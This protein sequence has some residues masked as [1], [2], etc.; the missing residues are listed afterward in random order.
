MENREDVEK[1]LGEPIFDEFSENTLR[2]RRNLFFVSGVALFYKIGQL[3]ISEGQLGFFTIKNL[4]PEF[5]DQALFWVVAYLLIHFIWNSWSHFQE[6]HL[7]LTATRVAPITGG[8]WT[9]D[10][11]D[12]PTDP[13]Q[14]TLYNWWLSEAGR[15]GNIGK[16]AASIIETVKGWDKRIEDAIP[17]NQKINLENIIHG[18]T[19]MQSKISDMTRKIEQ[20]EKTLSSERIPAS[21][22]RF[23][24]S[25]WQFQKNQLARW[26]LVEWL[27]PI[28]L[29]VW[30]FSLTWP[31]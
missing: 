14:S 21:L 7:R 5:V 30:A 3:E 2:I 23:D 22:E 18:L 9:S 31:F 27:L 29:G 13:K 28:T 24:K 16:E 17:S 25:F 6:F 8:M 11:A 19:E 12:Y 1:I 4:R 15:I 10:E 20:V 26:F